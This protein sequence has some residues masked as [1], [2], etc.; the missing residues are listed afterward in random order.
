MQLTNKPTYPLTLLDEEEARKT[1]LVIVITTEVLSSEKER[2]T[3]LQDLINKEF[4]D[5]NGEI[6]KLN[7]IV[8]TGKKDY[9]LLKFITYNLRFNNYIE[10]NFTSVKRSMSLEDF[11]IKAK[12]L[13][14]HELVSGGTQEDLLYIDN[15][16][17]FK[18]V[19]D[20]FF[21]G[22]QE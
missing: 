19:M 22:R 20:S 17:N 16:K 6:W 3:Y 15:A 5:S 10:F 21:F 18:T 8:N 12:Q 9:N 2:F 11:K 13:L 14:K 1:N 4:C 7:K